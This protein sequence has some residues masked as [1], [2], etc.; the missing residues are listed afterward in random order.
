MRLGI[1]VSSP[2]AMIGILS[3]ARDACIPPPTM[4]EAVWDLEPNR[5]HEF[6]FRFGWQF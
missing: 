4:V 5:Q 3:V 2:W 6:Q 1:G